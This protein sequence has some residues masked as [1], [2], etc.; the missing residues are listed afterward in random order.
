VKW[1]NNGMAVSRVWSG[2][3]L[4]QAA[5]QATYISEFVIPVLYTMATERPIRIVNKAFM[6]AC[7]AVT[8]FAIVNLIAMTAA[9]F[10]G[11][12]LIIPSASIALSLFITHRN[13][14]GPDPSEFYD[15]QHEA[16]VLAPDYS[17]IRYTWQMIRQALEVSIAY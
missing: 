7:T 9:S 15:R 10:P 2:M 5:W 16:T 4:P 6:T 11:A 12:S 3:I 13:L 1:L 17:F 14:T 8:D